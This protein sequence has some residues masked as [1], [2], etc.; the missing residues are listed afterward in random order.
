ENLP[1]YE[2]IASSLASGAIASAIGNP[3]D[4]SMVRMQSDTM[5]PKAERRGYKNVFDALIRIAREEGVFR[6][7][8]GSA[9][10]IVRAMAM[11]MGM[12][13]SYDQTKE[14][15][16]AINGD[17]FSTQLMSSATAGFFAAFISLPFDMM[18][19]R[20]QSMRVS[21]QPV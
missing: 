7:W 4:V 5:L 21:G 14:I 12:M 10:T 19:S 3:F 15:I 2:K 6:L 16:T 8:R 9:P 13:A 11:N 1:L 20:L 17:N 18:K